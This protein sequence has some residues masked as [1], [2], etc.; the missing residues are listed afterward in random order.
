MNPSRT[1]RLSPVLVYVLFPA[2]Q[3]PCP[4]DI[5]SFCEYEF[6]GSCPTYEE[7]AGMTCEG[8]HF[9]PSGGSGTA[10]TVGDGTDACSRPVVSCSEGGDSNRTTRIY[11]RD[12]GASAIEWVHLDWA[13]DDQCPSLVGVLGHADC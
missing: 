8:I 11:F 13:G 6:G 10:P 2:C 4:D 3:K 7:A 1:R 9:D 5:A 12:V